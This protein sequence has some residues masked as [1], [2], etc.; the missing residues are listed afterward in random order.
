[1]GRAASH[2]VPRAPCYSGEH[3]LT[4][5]YPCRIRDFHPLWCDFPDA[6]AIVISAQGIRNPG[7]NPGLGCSDFARRYSRNRCLFLFLQVLR[8]FSSLSS[9][10]TAYAFGGRLLHHCNRVS[11][12]R[13]PRIN[14]CLPAS[15]GLSQATTSFVASRCQDIHHTPLVA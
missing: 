12:F 8:C 7:A 3:I 11:P 4:G 2:G 9:L 6:S 1:M 15:R 5:T 10:L 14:A 13:H